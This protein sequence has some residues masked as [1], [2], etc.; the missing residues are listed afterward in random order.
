MAL[1]PTIYKCAINLSD[2]NRHYYDSLNLTLALHP[3]EKV[4]RMMARV[5]AY[6]LHAD[7]YLQFTKGLSEISE[8][9][10][11][12]HQLSGVMDT[13]IDVGEPGF[14][15]I[16]KAC[17]KA[18]AVYVYSFNSKS[19]T[20]WQQ[21]RQSFTGLSAKF[22]QFDAVEIEQL[23]GLLER[24]MQ[25]SVTLSEQSIFVTSDNNSLEVTWQEL[26]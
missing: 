16:K 20:W 25:W 22:Y 23:T 13:W 24:T 19:D 10:I 11:W 8:P 14:D 5:L 7:E 2:L 1:K 12:S 6:C 18:K 4:E 21:G 9:D 26:D 17:H 15:R 3:S